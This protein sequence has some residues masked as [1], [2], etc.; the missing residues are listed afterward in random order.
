DGSGF[1]AYPNAWL[2]LQRTNAFIIGYMSS[3]GTSWAIQN[4]L[5]T[6]TW[7]GGALS[8]NLLLGVAITSHQ[9]KTPATAEFRQFGDA[10]AQPIII[11][12]QPA[13]LMVMEGQT[14]AF[15]VG[16]AGFD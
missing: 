8:S 6:S 5:N 11:T 12:A 10:F 9:Q 13:N 14:A 1:P 3:N 2:R 16:L 7:Q 4:S 15:K